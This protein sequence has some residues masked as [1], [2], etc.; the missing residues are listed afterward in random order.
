MLSH[1]KIPPKTVENRQNPNHEPLPTPG[2]RSKISKSKQ[3]VVLHH[4]ETSPPPEDWILFPDEVVV[5]KHSTVRDVRCR[6][7]TQNLQ[8]AALSQP[9]TLPDEVQTRSKE[10]CFLNKES[11]SLSWSAD[12]SKHQLD[13]ARLGNELL[14]DDARKPSKFNHLTRLPTPEL[15]DVDED[16][17]W[18]C[19]GS[20]EGS[21]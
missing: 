3:D 16:G 18:S 1:T 8:F 17:F 20:S 6:K 14:W 15:S 21:T 7:A 2:R 11:R 13:V 5:T 12:G 9:S 10:K 4:P 19:C